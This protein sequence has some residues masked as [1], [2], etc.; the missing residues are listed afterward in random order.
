MAKRLS[1]KKPSPLDNLPEKS[2]YVSRGGDKLRGALDA[3][4]VSANGKICLDVGS[5]TG[6]FTDCLLQDGAHSVWAVDVGYGLLDYKLRNDPRIHLLERTNFRFLDLKRLDEQPTLATVDVSFI[7]LGQIFPVLK[8]ILPQGGEAI[9]LVKPQ[10]E[11]SRK[12]V[13]GGFVK[14]ET[15]RQQ[16]LERVKAMTIGAGFEIKGLSDSTVKGRKGNQETFLYLQ[17]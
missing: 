12:E 9:V 13:P 16:I 5:S 1:R 4:G 10:F 11:G 7:S 3:F 14:D 17:K 8:M 15:T 6:G 2:R